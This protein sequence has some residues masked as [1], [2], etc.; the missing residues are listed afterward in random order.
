M[1]TQVLQH[2]PVARPLLQ[3]AGRSLAGRIRRLAARHRIPT[4]PDCTVALLLDPYRFVGRR[5]A[6]LGSD[7][8]QSRFLLRRTIFLMGQDGAELFSN[9]AYFQ[10]H[11][12][13][14]QRLQRTLFG[15]GGVQTLDA[16]RHHQRKAMLMALVGPD[17]VQRLVNLTGRHL[18]AQAQG[19]E[20]GRDVDFYAE[21]RTVLTRAVCA[22][23][24]MPL[25]EADLP[26]RTQQLTALFDQVALFG[27]PHWR[28]WRMRRQAER[29][30]MD[31][32]RQV[33]GEEL[34]ASEHSALDVIARQRDNDGGL[35]PLRTAAVELLNVLRPVVAV[36]VYVVFVAMALEAHPQW[37]E[38]LQKDN[39]RALDAFV[40]E[41]RRFYPFFPQTVARTRRRFEW[42]GLKFPKGVRVMLDLYATN[43]DPRLWEGADTFHPERFLEQAVGAYD[44]IPQGAGDHYVNH[45][46]PGESLTVELMKVATKFFCRELRYELDA[47]DRELDWKRLPPLP[48]GF[49]LRR[50]VRAS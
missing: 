11:G 45:R 22:W 42:R 20:D 7:V 3:F 9:P 31:V 35:L 46:C 12:A 30:C 14:P 8:F 6:E 4:V 29:W 2:F 37:R 25:S 40:Q 26:V 44:F 27:P 28:A 39:G 41:V 50:V 36:S 18:R 1:A 17:Q 23:A 5:C 43:H 24:G 38:R 47:A 48:R 34:P 32:I 10:R 49:L 21:M 16:E 15:R 19:W 33:R 13:V